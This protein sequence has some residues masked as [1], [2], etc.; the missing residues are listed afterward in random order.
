MF[1][2]KIEKI[3]KHILRP[4]CFE[5]NVVYEV[6]W[7]NTVQPGRLQMTILRMC[8]ACWIPKATNTH[9]EYA[10]FIAF[11]TVTM[12]ARTRLHVTFFVHCLSCSIRSLNLPLHKI[13]IIRWVYSFYRLRW[14]SGSVLA[15]ST[16]VRGF[17]PGRSRRIFRAKKSSARLPSEGK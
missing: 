6:M 7:K 4:T 14:S 3:K 15:F 8:I 13:S 10:I 16:Q 5:T 2:K 1:Q 11:S 12:V 9:W 17:K